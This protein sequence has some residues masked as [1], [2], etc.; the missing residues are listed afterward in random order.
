[1]NS[2][3]LS[4]GAANVLATFALALVVAACQLAP[5]GTEQPDIKRVR[6]NGTELSYVEQGRGT[7]VV[8]VHG[9][10]GDWRIWENQRPWWRVG[11]DSSRT[12]AA[13]TRRTP[14]RATART[15]RNLSTWMI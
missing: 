8:F 11:I 13:T 2:V 14:G 1:M 4:G 15:I 9:S 5:V 7:P 3:R 12:A 6:V 10:A